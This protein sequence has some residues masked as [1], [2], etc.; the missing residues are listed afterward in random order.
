MHRS[1]SPVALG[2]AVLLSACGGPV[3]VGTGV[4]PDVT[5]P[6]LRSAAAIATNATVLPSLATVPPLQ[7]STSDVLG[8]A[9][10]RSRFAVSLA[11]WDAPLTAA[12]GHVYLGIV[13]IE[14]RQQS[15]FTML[16]SY[17]SPHVVDLLELQSEP[18]AVPG[19]LPAG[20]Y[21]GIRLLVDPQ[22]SRVEVDGRT[23]PMTFASL[24]GGAASPSSTVAMDSDL[25]FSV[26]R[27]TAADEGGNLRLG[28]DVN[29]LESVAIKDGMAY[30][31]PTMIASEKPGS[32]HG[33]VVNERGKPVKSATVIAVGADGAVVNTTVTRADG[34]FSIHSLNAGNYR[35]EIRAAYTTAQGVDV[36]A[37]GA[38]RDS[39][40]SDTFL[41]PPGG[42]VDLGTLID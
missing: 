19:T 41:L 4:V 2:A 24:D 16:A 25:A 9:P 39:N 31:R 11:I 32:V 17:T 7:R 3:T 38:T 20:S 12:G 14:A 30:V 27:N 21:D 6:A 42:R 26:G 33:R 34:R 13:G 10:P 1:M 22:A 15:T 8:G 5:P 37:V 40:Q 29:V 18:L 36:H 28:L 35:L 23:Y